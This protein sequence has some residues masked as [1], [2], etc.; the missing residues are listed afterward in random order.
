VDRTA[1]VRTSGPRERSNKALL[2]LEMPV[3]LPSCLKLARIALM[4][5]YVYVYGSR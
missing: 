5:E 1:K 4:N 3:L 2:L